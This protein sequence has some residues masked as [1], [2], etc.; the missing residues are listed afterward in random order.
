MQKWRWLSI[1]LAI[2]LLIPAANCSPDDDEFGKFDGVFYRAED[3]PREIA[4]QSET[5]DD[6]FNEFLELYLNHYPETATWVGELS[7]I[8]VICRD[9]ELDS[10][11]PDPWFYE[12]S[13]S[14]LNKLSAFPDSRLSGDQLLHKDVLQWTLE[15]WLESQSFEWHGYLVNHY[16]GFQVNF[17]LFMQTA[18]DIQNVRDAENY[19]SRLTASQRAMEETITAIED[20]RRQGIL[21]PKFTVEKTINSLRAF[22]STPPENNML[23]TVFA[24]KLAELDLSQDKQAELHSLVLD[25]LENCVYPAYKRLGAYLKQY[26]PAEEIQGVWSL[27]RGKEYYEFLVRYY[28]ST[29]M[30]P[31][32]VHEL[33]LEL[34]KETKGQIMEVLQ[35]MGMGHLY[36]PEA[37]NEIARGHIQTDREEILTRYRQILEEAHGLLPKYFEILPA[38]PVRI[39]PIPDFLAQ[40]SSHYYTRPSRN[41]VRPGIFHINLSFDHEG[42]TMRNLTF[43]ET[44]P[45]HHLQLSLQQENPDLPLFCDVAN[46]SAFTEGWATYSEGLFYEHDEFSDDLVGRIGWL[47]YE[48][49]GAVM[50]VAETGL[51]YFGW[52]EAQAKEYMGKE[53]GWN[54]DLDRY[55]V[56]PGQVLSYQVG[57]WYI[58][59][60][61]HQ[62][63]EQLGEAF[64][65][66]E[67]HSAILENGA[68]PLVILKEQVE[69]WIRSKKQRDAANAAFF[70]A[71]ARGVFVCMQEMSKRRTNIIFPVPNFNNL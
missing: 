44:V 7:G 67:F 24:G 48:L 33:G 31:G 29:D 17:P 30:T 56:W 69:R 70:L 36:L 63:M 9:G 22:V 16:N 52:S 59:D 66:R 50:L 62:A 58:R 40:Y 19:I 15:H 12:F 38:S 8:N 71:T 55:L 68:M 3:E 54:I 25:A 2:L 45:G 61:R 21:S 35:Q 51:H 1:I 39:E 5:I 27:P 60:L 10:R 41:G 14:A 65:I 26:T 32:E 11:V 46:F 53:L 37:L 49:F 64:D 4:F 13:K 43:H 18:H 57:A 23:F 6:F 34:V 42:H 47:E 28:T 20:Q